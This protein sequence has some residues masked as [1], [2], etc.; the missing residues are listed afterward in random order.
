[1]NTN[2]STSRIV[3]PLDGS[4]RAEQ[5]LLY[6]RSLAQA[7]DEIIL[8]RVMPSPIETADA[9]GRVINANNESNRRRHEFAMRNLHQ[10]ATTMRSVSG[11]KIDLIVTD[12]EVAEQI[13]R[14]ATDRAADMIVMSSEG[15]RA[16]RRPGLGSVADQVVRTSQIPVLVVRASLGVRE[17]DRSR[18]RRFVVPLD[19][20]ERSKHALTTAENLAT[21]LSVPVMLVSVVDPEQHRQ[22]APPE[23]GASDLQV[24][25]DILSKARLAAEHA[26]E[27][28]S[29]RLATHGIVESVQL[30]SGSAAPTLLNATCAGDVIIITSRGGHGRNWPLGSV[31]EAL[32]GTGPVPVVLV[33]I[34]SESGVN[35]P[36]GTDADSQFAESLQ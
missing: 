2:Q 17:P 11:L 3:I 8:L 13:N 19:G 16:S 9:R 1:M 5:A 21:R 24:E 6:A 28:A 32:V 30:L 18:I 20:S 36:V 22:A 29:A 12:G 34:P 23:A 35:L 26:L 10:A 27:W 31:A 14:I 4:I 33:P 7:G 25:H 15:T